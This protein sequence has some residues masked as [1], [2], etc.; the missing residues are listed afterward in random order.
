MEQYFR[1]VF[2]GNLVTQLMKIPQFEDP[3]NTVQ[4]LVDHNITIFEYEYLFENQRNV[5][6]NL[7]D[8]DW[9]KVV[10]N[11]VSAQQCGYC[12]DTNGTYHF[13]IKHHVHGNKTHAFIKGYLFD[14][15]IELMYYNPKTKRRLNMKNFNKIWWRSHKVLNDDINTYGGIMTSRNWILNEVDFFLIF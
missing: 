6:L 15:D 2:L 14:E 12:Y 3:I 11:M 4:D 1:E 10:N 9:A 13:Y 5:Y 8:E 7:K